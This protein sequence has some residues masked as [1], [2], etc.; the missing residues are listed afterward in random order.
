MKLGA[1][2]PMGPLA[3]ADLIGIDNCLKILEEFSKLN[4]KYT[5]CPMFGEMVRKGHKGKKT[6][7]GF[8]TY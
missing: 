5:P 2:F 6:G 1:N 3:L 8:Y 7:K 4:E